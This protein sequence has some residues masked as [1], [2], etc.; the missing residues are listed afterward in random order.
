MSIFQR[1]AV[2][3][4]GVISHAYEILPKLLAAL[5][6]FGFDKWETAIRDALHKG[7]L[8]IDDFVE[9]HAVK[10][11]SIACLFE[12][13]GALFMSKAALLRELHEEGTRP[14]TPREEDLFDEARV[15]YYLRAFAS[16][17]ALMLDLQGAGEEV[18]LELADA[19]AVEPRPDVSQSPTLDC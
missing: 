1:A 14:R 5:Q 7:G 17:D 12:K 16:H 8:A 4:W 18:H 11:I 15:A 13:I 9:L 3:F 19:A 2:L 10:I 6:L